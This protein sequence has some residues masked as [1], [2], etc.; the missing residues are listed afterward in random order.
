MARIGEI[1]EIKKSDVPGGGY[2]LGNAAG[3]ALDCWY[4]KLQGKGKEGPLSTNDSK[5]SLVPY[6]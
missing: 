6:L 2:D 5:S 3:P 4:S 1:I